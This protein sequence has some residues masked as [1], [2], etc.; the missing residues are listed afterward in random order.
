MPHSLNALIGL[1][2]LIKKHMEVVDSVTKVALAALIHPS[3][4]GL[5]GLDSSCN[6]SKKI[7]HTSDPMA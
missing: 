3:T 5:A 2:A 6:S 1:V 4:A 7:K